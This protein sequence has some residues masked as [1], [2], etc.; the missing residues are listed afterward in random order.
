MIPFLPNPNLAEE[1]IADAGVRAGLARSAEPGRVQAEAFAREAGA[2][3]M[4]RPGAQ[5][6]QVVTDEEGVYLV[7]TDFAAHLQEFGSANN[8]AHAP[9]R[10]GAMAAGLRVVEGEPLAAPT[11]IDSEDF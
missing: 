11:G 1:L 7:N 6:V 2:P 3:W 10:R 5:I 8:P 9:L 4:P